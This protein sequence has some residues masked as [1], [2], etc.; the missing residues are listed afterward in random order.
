[1]ALV[2]FRE[3]ARRLAV[4]GLSPEPHQAAGIYG[5]F[6]DVFRS[7]IRDTDVVAHEIPARGAKAVSDE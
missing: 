7:R 5:S 3:S 1:M 2:F 6:G 4:G